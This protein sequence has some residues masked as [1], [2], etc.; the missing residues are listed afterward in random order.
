MAPAFR[1]AALLLGLAVAT[2]AGADPNGDRAV[3]ND[4]C[5]TNSNG[6]FDSCVRMC[7]TNQEIYNTEIQTPMR[8][9][10][11]PPTLFGAIA[12]ETATLITGMARD[13]ASRD[14]A[15]RRAIAMCRRAGGSAAG[16]KLVTVKNN[17]CIALATSRGTGGKA[18]RW[19][20]ATS[21][22]GWVSRR[23][24]VKYCRGD[25]GTNCQVVVAF[26]TG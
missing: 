16:C 2:A 22:D 26:C 9:M 7:M 6:N 3:C 11:R 25:G 4:Q 21:D 12:V 23:D 17:A 13:Y 20:Y 15:E 1:L 8:P 10:P 14:G 24:A 18:N 19:G 5:T